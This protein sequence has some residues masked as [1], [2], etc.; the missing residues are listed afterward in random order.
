MSTQSSQRIEPED[1]APTDLAPHSE[2]LP[3]F[4]L[5]DS[6]SSGSYYNLQ[7]MNQMHH[8]IVRRI[9]IGQKDHM[10]A[11]DLG[12]TTATVK[13]TRESP[14]VKQKLRILNGARD[15]SFTEVQQRILDMAPLALHEMEKIMN[16][17]A[18][19]GSVRSKVAMDILDRAGY[20]AVQKKV[21][22]TRLSEDRINSIKERA[23]NAGMDFPDEDEMEDADYEDIRNGEL[24]DSI[25]E[26]G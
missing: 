12:C 14:V 8:E 11:K 7:K 2:S 20:G 15:E 23:Q 4:T 26:D 24:G 10:I 21:D 16:D 25:P 18:E 13:Y 3:S 1:M 19:T 17:Q 6:Q 5:P 9:V 22:L